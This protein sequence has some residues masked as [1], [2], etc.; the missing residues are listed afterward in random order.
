MAELKTGVVQY[1]NEKDTRV[2][3][4]YNI[5]LEGDDK[6]YGCYKSRPTVAEGQVVEFEFSTNGQG[7]HNIDM[8]KGIRVLET[9]VAVSDGVQSEAQTERAVAAKKTSDGKGE[10]IA[11]QSA[12]NTAAALLAVAASADALP[13][14][15]KKDGKLEALTILF[16]QL[17]EELYNDGKFVQDN[18]TSPFAEEV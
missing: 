7:F 14:G 3:K 11:W 17:T 8:K 6:Y 10:R 9:D 13:L 12:R 2:G 4:T 1:V 5:R 16:N 15:A 18:G